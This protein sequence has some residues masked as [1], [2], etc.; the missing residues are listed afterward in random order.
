MKKILNKPVLPKQQPKF[1]LP[2]GSLVFIGEKKLEQPVV[3][4]FEYDQSDIKITEI[5]SSDQINQLNSKDKVAWLNVDGL[6]DIKLVEKIGELYNL[7]PLLLEDILH[8]DQRPKVDH[9][10]NVIFLVVKMLS[11]HDDTNSVWAEQVSFVLGKN[12]LLTFQEGALGDVFDAVRE[13]LIHSKGKIRKYNVDYLMYELLD[14]IVD[15]YFIIIE[16]AGDR[17][18]QIEDEILHNP[19]KKIL[20]RIHDLKRE[21]ISLRKTIWPLRDLINRLE[22]GDDDI[23]SDKNIRIYLSDLFDHTIQ[24]IETIETYRDML[25][26]LENLYLSSL[27]NKMNEVM[28][29]LTIITTIFIPL[30]FIAGVYGMNFKFMPELDIPIAYPIVLIAMF[31]IGI[32]MIILFKKKKWF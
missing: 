4:L 19:S 32:A 20:L 22:K 24:E 14:A 9:Y 31:V 6:H 25:S 28:K 5:K 7:H 12:F 16:K 10:E 23:L 26:S 1:G 13:R 2:P 21:L 30:S 17:L 27:S 15:N 8:T 18:E 11:Y 29:V 3:H